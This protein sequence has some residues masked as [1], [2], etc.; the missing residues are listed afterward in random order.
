M[1]KNNNT[2]FVLTPKLTLKNAYDKNYNLQKI[3]N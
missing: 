3:Q 1:N 2:V